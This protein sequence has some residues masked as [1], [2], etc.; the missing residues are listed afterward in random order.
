MNRGHGHG[1][2]GEIGA[3]ELDTD[4]THIDIE[5]VQKNTEPELTL[6]QEVEKM[7]DE[8]PEDSDLHQTDGDG[9]EGTISASDAKAE[10]GFSFPSFTGS[11]LHT[12]LLESTVK[13]ATNVSNTCAEREGHNMID[14]VFADIGE[15]MQEEEDL[16]S[17]Q[18]KGNRR[19]FRMVR[20]HIKKNRTESFRQQVLRSND[21]HF[22]QHVVKDLL[23]DAD[24][25]GT[26]STQ[27]QDARSDFQGT[28][29]DTAKSDQ[30]ET[31]LDSQRS[32]PAATA[33]VSAE[34]SEMKSEQ[35]S[36]D[37]PYEL[38]SQPGNHVNPSV[39]C[40]DTTFRSSTSDHSS[41]TA[42]AEIAKSQPS[43]CATPQVSVKN[44]SLPDPTTLS[45]RYPS[46]HVTQPSR[47]VKTV[48]KGLEFQKDALQ[49]LVTDDQCNSSPEA[50][51]DTLQTALADD[52]LSTCYSGIESAHTATNCNAFALSEATGTERVRV[53]L[54]HM[55]EW[56]KENQKEL[57]L[58]AHDHPGCCLFGDVSG[59]FREEIQ[60]TV[61]PQLKDTGF[62]HTRVKIS[63]VI[64]FTSF[65]L[66]C[67]SILI[68][69]VDYL[70]MG[71][72]VCII[73]VLNLYDN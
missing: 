5:Q 64:E 45:Y 18:I 51:M 38:H 37:A 25:R 49:F 11:D 50:V 70:L 26:L 56:D 27:L 72:D 55:I 62:I 30:M 60:T 48:Q 24:I 34:K 35:R 8:L 19:R 9:D 65:E 59:F 73:I 69:F 1:S 47:I 21:V 67:I 57:L 52:S 41:P 39:A 43:S 12:A 63:S 7:I 16:L 53:P 66:V 4:K 36:S 33:H 13:V 10:A 46:L 40:A 22:A 2:A 23:D 42:P 17:N 54:Y 61:I 44:T 31:C 15:S 14:D 68:M 32:S 71:L 6:S 58:V 28:A 29:N 3:N 20:G